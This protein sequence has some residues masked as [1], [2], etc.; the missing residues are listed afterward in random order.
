MTTITLPPDIA[1]P[2]TEAAR[3]Q[4]KSPEQ[5][6]LDSLRKLFVAAVSNE[7]RTEQSL[8]DFLAGHI[9][10]IAGSSEALS[11]KCG[12]RFADGL[13]TKYQSKTP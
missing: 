12:Q 3:K 6:A 5:L 8:F 7:H 10:T 13:V 2:L 1:D 11:E 9:G 4:G